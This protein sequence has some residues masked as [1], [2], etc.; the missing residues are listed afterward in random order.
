M[1]KEQ[2]YQQIEKFYNSKETQNDSKVIGDKYFY[3]NTQKAIDS[4]KFINNLINKKKIIFN[5]SLNIMDLCFGSG[6]LTSHIVLDTPLNTQNIYFN[7]IDTTVTNQDIKIE[8]K[9]E[10]LN[11]DFLDFKQFEKYKKSIDLLI[12]NPTISDS[13]IYRKISVKESDKVIE[14]NNHLD[15]KVSFKEYCENLSLKIMNDIEINQ[16]NKTIKVQIEGTKKLL[17]KLPNSFNN[18]SLICKTKSMKSYENRTSIVTQINQTI[19]SLL[20]DDGI[21]IFVGTDKQQEV[22]FQLYNR[23]FRYLQDE[24]DVF[25]IS[26]SEINS[27]EC[28]EKNQDGFIKNDD[29]KLIKTNDTKIKS[30]DKIEVDTFEDENKKELKEENKA[31]KKQKETEEFI[32]TP[33]DNDWKF[34]HKNLLLKGV[35]GTGKSHTLEKIIENHLKLKA[36]PKNICHINI[37]SASSNA[38]LMQGIGINSNGGKIEY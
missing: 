17:N 30:F 6:N 22:I 8:E 18:Y 24:K 36:K 21:I 7:D 37:H 10:V 34:S 26:K 13:D 27:I 25:V 33:L 32:N 3:I 1:G 12:F 20:K 19:S 16:E 5:S 23:V 2:I 11:L 28:F 4:T 35:P 15:I 9:S 29:C 31:I 38:D 14:Y